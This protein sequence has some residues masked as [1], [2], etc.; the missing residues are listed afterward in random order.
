MAV[1]RK[2]RR[3]YKCRCIQIKQTPTMW[4]AFYLVP[5]VGGPGEYPRK[6]SRAYLVEPHVPCLWRREIVKRQIRK[7]N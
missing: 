1:I 4:Q 6:V 7:E 3:P 2:A 5:N